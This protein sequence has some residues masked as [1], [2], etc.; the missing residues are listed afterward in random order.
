MAD[1]PIFFRNKVIVSDIDPECLW[2]KQGDD[3]VLVDEDQYI[4][5]PFLD[6]SEQ[7]YQVH[8]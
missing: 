4:A 3:L 5:V 2:V 6:Y 7:F 8:D 1:E